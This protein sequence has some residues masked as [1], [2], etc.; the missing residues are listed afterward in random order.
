[1][2]T[3]LSWGEI[4]GDIITVTGMPDYPNNTTLSRQF[5]RQWATAEGPA[6]MKD[7]KFIWIYKYLT[8]PDII[9]RPEFS[10][11][12]KLNEESRWVYLGA[13]IGRLVQSNFS[14]TCMTSCE[15]SSDNV[16][17][18]V[19]PNFHTQHGAFKVESE[20][21]ESLE[22][23]NGR[24]DGVYKRIG[25]EEEYFILEYE[26]SA[27]IIKTFWIEVQSKNLHRDHITIKRKAGYSFINDG[28]FMVLRDNLTGNCRQYSIVPV[29]SNAEG[30]VSKFYAF[31]DR[32]MLDAFAELVHKN[33]VYKDTDTRN[34]DFKGMI[35]YEKL[36][37]EERSKFI[38]KYTDILYEV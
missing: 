16:E 29:Y 10:D 5:L 30:N 23:A 32:K 25:R 33:G 11:V 4:I 34:F 15:I 26:E 19:V 1:M 38:D 22:E 27:K 20:R 24:L 8:H 2:S 7:E 3:E 21:Y 35:P 13:A 31:E 28:R 37:G 14:A 12:T 6:K 17:S 36:A 9:S 18:L